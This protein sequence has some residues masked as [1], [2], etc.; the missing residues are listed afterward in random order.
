[1]LE[2]RDSYL[3]SVLSTDADT[4]PRTTSV[5]VDST[6]LLAPP[7]EDPILRV[8]L[9]IPAHMLTLVTYDNG[10]Q[11]SPIGID[12]FTLWCQ[13]FHTKVTCPVLHLADEL[14]VVF[15]H[16]WCQEHKIVICYKEEH[17]TFVYKDSPHVFR[18]G[19]SHA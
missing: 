13:V 12:T 19:N 9:D 2:V 14:D 16:K 5:G 8:D 11:A 17:A 18:F 3:D 6:N 10:N 7:L 15:G 1:M 4:S